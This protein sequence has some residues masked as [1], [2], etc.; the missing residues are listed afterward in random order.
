LDGILGFTE[1]FVGLESYNLESSFGPVSSPFDFETSVFNDFQNIPTSGGSLSL[2]ANNDT[3]TAVGAAP[4]PGTLL[5]AG[6]GL[7]GVL[8][9]RR[10]SGKT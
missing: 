1:L 10:A 3:F 5:V 4:E 8:A 2:V 9:C 7:L 6:L